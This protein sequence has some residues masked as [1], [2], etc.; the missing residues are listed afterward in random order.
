MLA[1]PGVALAI[2]DEPIAIFV[3]GFGNS[4]G[5]RACPHCRNENE[6]ANHVNFT[7]CVGITSGHEHDSN[8]SQ[9]GTV[10]HSVN[11]MV[12]LCFDLDIDVK[13]SLEAWP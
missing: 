9:N 5:T 8:M 2:I 12:R 3:V 4:E 1:G 11:T 13:I 7:A 10:K 6:I